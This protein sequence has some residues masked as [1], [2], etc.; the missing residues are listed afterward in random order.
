MQ[1]LQLQV[2]LPPQQNTVAGSQGSSG[3]NENGPH[4]LTGSSIIGDGAL[5]EEVH[6]LG[7]ALGF[8]RLKPGPVAHCRCCLQIRMW[9]SQLPLQHH[10]CLY[11]A[12]LPAIIMT[13]P[14]NLKPQLNFVFYKS[15]LDHGISS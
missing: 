3:K 13:E 11:T 8:Q 2:W 5:L 10:I 9:N 7:W 6:H 1:P 12:M 14:L 4:G 15:F